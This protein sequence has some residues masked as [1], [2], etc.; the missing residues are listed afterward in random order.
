MCG[1]LTIIAG[2][3]GLRRILIRP[4]RIRID[5]LMLILRAISVRIGRIV[6]C[7]RRGTILKISM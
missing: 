4:I 5:V 2:M 1:G 7:V 6:M 3:W